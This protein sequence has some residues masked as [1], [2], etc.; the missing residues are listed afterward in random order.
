MPEREQPVLKRERFEPQRLPNAEEGA[1]ASAHSGGS[2]QIA[3][4]LQVAYLL[5]GSVA[6]ICLLIFLISAIWSAF[7]SKTV[8][9]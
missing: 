3:L 2:L 5:S 4:V 8:V 7:L 1:R 9:R 6:L